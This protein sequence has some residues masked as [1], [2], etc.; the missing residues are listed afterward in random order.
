MIR[1][2]I[3]SILFHLYR[4][5]ARCWLMQQKRNTINQLLRHTI[6]L[7]V[8]WNVHCWHKLHFMFYWWRPS[9]SD[10]CDH[11]SIGCWNTGGYV[12]RSN[13]YTASSKIHFSILLFRIL[14]EFYA[15]S[16]CTFL[17]CPRLWLSKSS[18]PCFMRIF[19][20]ISDRIQDCGKNL[21]KR[22]YESQLSQSVT[23]LKGVGLFFYLSSYVVWNLIDHSIFFF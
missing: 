20:S 16:L 13:F 18:L 12:M 14:I 7:Y 10:H 11:F 2:I 15:F 1:L 21:R 8:T 19:S 23:L 5:A 22:S 6:N 3:L 4:H 17:R 9:G